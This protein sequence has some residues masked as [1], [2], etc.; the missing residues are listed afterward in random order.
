MINQPADNMQQDQGIRK[1]LAEDVQAAA[2]ILNTAFLEDPFNTFV[3]PS[4]RLRQKVLARFYFLYAVAAVKAGQAFGTG[5][6]LGGVAIWN[7]PGQASVSINPFAMAPFFP[8]LLT[9]YYP[10]RL[11]RVVP[12]IRAQ[13]A[14]HKKHA[15][16]LH[17]YLCNIA[18]DASSRGQ[19][20]AS[21]LI[22]PVLARAEAEHKPVYTDT[23][24][25]S[26]VPLYQHLGFTCVEQRRFSSTK[27]AVWGF[28]RSPAK[29][30]IA[31][32][33]P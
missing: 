13:E 27:L 30:P 29:T 16:G 22:R 4:R 18:V 12:V 10:L 32:V 25:E 24:L 7:Y 31:K 21:G 1:L 3:L 8:L 19:G 33:P 23:F 11:L 6:P 26:N 15:P 14:F 2:S 5:E 20:L 9:I 28:L 17:Y